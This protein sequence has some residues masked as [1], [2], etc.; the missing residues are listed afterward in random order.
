MLRR[1]AQILQV[2]VY[3]APFTNLF[4]LIGSSIPADLSNSTPLMEAV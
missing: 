4:S 1:R 2:L 3:C